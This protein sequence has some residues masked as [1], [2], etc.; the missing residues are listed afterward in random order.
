MK[1]EKR[2]MEMGDL[3]KR[4][5]LYSTRHFDNGYGIKQ[6]VRLMDY[7]YFLANCFHGEH[8]NSKEDAI[9]VFN[10][11]ITSFVKKLL[12]GCK[13]YWEE[14]GGVKSEKE[15]FEQAFGFSSSFK[16]AEIFDKIVDGKKEA[17][18]SIVAIS[19]KLLTKRF[20]DSLGFKISHLRE[21][22]HVA[23]ETATERLC[24]FPS[25]RNPFYFIEGADF[26]MPLSSRSSRQE[27]SIDFQE[28]H[29]SL[30]STLYFV[31]LLDVSAMAP[32][33]IE[34]YK[35]KSSEGISIGKLHGLDIRAK[36]I[37]SNATDKKC[38]THE[39]YNFPEDARIWRS[40]NVKSRSGLEYSFGSGGDI[41][42]LLTINNSV[43]KS[44]L[45][46]YTDTKFDTSD[47]QFELR[48]VIATV[49]A[50]LCS[51]SL[52]LQVKNQR[53]CNP[54]RG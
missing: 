38:I 2:K 45:D 25:E 30:T 12:W 52:N 46:K 9:G 16:A 27:H 35:E 24:Q 21:A 13:E 53:K 28:I 41:S 1:E 22:K 33:L 39:N 31:E 47:E 6:D 11:P 20:G 44:V 42:L 4:S 10:Y 37:H 51:A 40:G 7:P 17:E 15:F 50:S 48:D 32:N 19:A 14:K 23:A 29:S 36:L 5:N 34:A 43:Q 8:R 3:L 49:Y 26:L 54:K 18:I